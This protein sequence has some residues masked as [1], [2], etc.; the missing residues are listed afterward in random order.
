VDTPDDN[1]SSAQFDA[2]GRVSYVASS[3]IKRIADGTVSLVVPGTFTSIVVTPT[4]Y[5]AKAFGTIYH[6]VETQN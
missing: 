2:A 6:I 4:G 5:W 3:G 1:V